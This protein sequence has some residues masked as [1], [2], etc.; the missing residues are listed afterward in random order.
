[1]ISKEKSKKNPAKEIAISP[2][3]KAEIKK[4]S[5]E[6]NAKISIPKTKNMKDTKKRNVK[7]AA[8]RRKFNA[9]ETIND[10]EEAVT[11]EALTATVTN[12]KS[13]M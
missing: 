8:F 13:K 1:V 4:N 9:A 11:P 5:K 12:S 3:K 7:K 6:Q 2:T 10:T